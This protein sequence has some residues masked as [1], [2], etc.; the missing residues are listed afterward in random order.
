MPISYR[1]KALV[2]IRYFD[3]N[4]VEHEC[5][6]GYNQ[7]KI[8]YQKLKDAP[9]LA[10][11]K[12]QDM[13]KWEIGLSQ[14]YSC[15]Y[16]WYYHQ[17]DT[18]PYTNFRFKGVSGWET[19]GMRITG[20]T[21]GKKY[22]WQFQILQVYNETTAS[23]KERALSI[24][25]IKDDYFFDISY[26]APSEAV[27]SDVDY[28]GNALAQTLLI[29]SPSEITASADGLWTT[30]TFT[31]DTGAAWIATNWGKVYDSQVWNVTFG[32]MMVSEGDRPKNFKI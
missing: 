23:Q 26:S 31:A 3:K 5:Y 20:L 4:L 25:V 17:S 22:T 29:F 15:F 21:P 28:K 1:K 11:P 9:N 32:K 7:D 8:V 14:F 2:D 18:D 6:L 24:A 30:L 10:P 16:D 13:S 27:T 12:V 19:I